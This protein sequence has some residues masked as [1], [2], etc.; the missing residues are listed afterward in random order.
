VAYVTVFVI[1]GLSLVML[2]VFIYVFRSKVHI[3][4]LAVAIPFGL[5]YS[6]I[7]SPGVVPDEAAHMD[8][9]YRYSNQMMCIN[10]VDD[11]VI[12]YR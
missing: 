3:V 12:R 5:I 1:L 7:M 10:H 9:A 8:M 2:Y 6:L 4:F 11:V